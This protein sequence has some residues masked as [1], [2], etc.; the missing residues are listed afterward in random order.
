MNDAIKKIKSKKIITLV[1]T[2]PTMKNTKINNCLTILLQ[3]TAFFLKNT[4]IL[5]NTTNYFKILQNNAKYCK[6]RQN[7][8]KYCKI[9]QLMHNTT[10]F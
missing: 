5:Q 2:L 8:A 7:T 1:P 4:A 3:N 6:T 9:L 10:K